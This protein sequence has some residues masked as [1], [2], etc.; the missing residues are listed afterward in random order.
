LSKKFV[1]LTVALLTVSI[2]PVARAEDPH[3]HEQKALMYSEYYCNG[4]GQQYR[5]DHYYVD[6]MLHYHSD[7]HYEPG[8]GYWY[9]KNVYVGSFC[10]I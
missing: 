4:L 5:T 10:A 1:V 6:V 3:V 7:D 2:A 9:T 8:N